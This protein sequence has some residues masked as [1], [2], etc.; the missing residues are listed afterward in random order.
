MQP[1]GGKRR[2]GGVFA[3]EGGGIEDFI[4]KNTFGR[5]RTE[6]SIQNM[7]ELGLGMAS[8]WQQ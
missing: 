5:R 6:Q 1:C 2:T 4:Q 7:T 3:E 8:T